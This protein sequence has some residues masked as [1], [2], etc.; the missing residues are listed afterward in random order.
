M[1]KLLSKF[2]CIVFLAYSLP[3]FSDDARNSGISNYIANI[4][5][6]T[7][8]ELLSVLMRVDAHFVKGDLV[9]GVGEP[10]AFVLHGAEAHS[11]KRENY[12]QNKVMV[13]LAAKLTAFGVID[14]KVCERWM[15]NN[16]IDVDQLQP[17]IGTVASGPAEQRRLKKELHYVEF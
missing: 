6:H 8:A 9:A 13:D 15:G 2:L 12:Q 16:Q 1:H 4:E 11:L 14:V 10:V 17:F 3:G 5:L 7:S